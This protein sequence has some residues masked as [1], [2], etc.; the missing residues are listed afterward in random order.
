MKEMGYKNKRD[1]NR[2][3]KS[4]LACILCSRSRKPLSEEHKAKI[5]KNHARHMLGKAHSASAREKISVG[6]T[7]KQISAEHRQRNRIAQS[8]RHHSEETRKKL[9]IALS[10]RVGT[11]HSAESKAK[12]RD[13]F[14][15]RKETAIGRFTPSYNRDACQLFDEINRELRWSGKHAENGGEVIV[16][17]WFLDYYEP[18]KNIAIEYDEPKHNQP[19]Q[20]ERD[21]I[22]QTKIIEHLGCKFYRIKQ[23]DENRWREI[24]QQCSL[25]AVQD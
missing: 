22:K 21:E 14:A 6:N 24:L 17:G 7:G 15:K 19:K 8:G 3:N 23:G 16:C 9:S 20:K 1:V 4:N 25:P 2:A 5:R 10:G 13:A 18:T 12:M 11:P